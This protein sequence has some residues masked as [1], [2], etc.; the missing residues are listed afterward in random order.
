MRPQVAPRISPIVAD[1]NA[2]RL[3]VSDGDQRVD[4]VLALDFVNATVAEH[5]HDGETT[6][7]KSRETP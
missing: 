2:R 5:A 1:E 6:A 3:R 7:V 4:H